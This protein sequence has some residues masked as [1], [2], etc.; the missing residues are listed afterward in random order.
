MAGGEG[1]EVRGP[2]EGRVAEVLSD[3]ALAFLASL[4]REFNPER[5]ALL[6]RR[7]ESQAR[8]V[9][10]ESL[11]FLP[12]TRELRD[13]EWKVAPPPKDLRDRRV[14]IT[15]PTDR[16]M[17]INAL[18]SGAR[19]FMADFEDSNSPT[20]AN[21]SEGHVNLIDAIEGT[22]SYRSPDGRDYRLGEE[23][24]TLL[25]RPRGWHLWDRHLLVEGEPIAGALMDFGLFFF[26]NARR[27]LDKGSGPYLYLPKLQSHLE[28]RLWNDVFNFSQDALGIDRGTIK[29]TVLIETVPAA[30]E[31]DEILYEL[32]DHS[33]GLNAGR[34]DY[35]FSMIKCFRTR[36]EFV[37]PDRNS[38]TMTVPFMRAYTQLLVN[39]CHRRG[40][41]AMGGM[42][43]FI[44][45][46][47]QPEI[48]EGAFAKVADDKRREATDGFDGTWIAHPD[49]VEVAQQEF[50]NVLADRPNQVDRVRDEVSV[51]AAE[52]LDVAATE[53]AITEEGLRNDC[54]VGIQYISSWLRGNGAAGIYNLMEDA[55]TAEI[56][57]SQVW[58]WVHTGQ[59]LEEGPAITPELVRELE[60]SELERIRGEIGDDDWFYREGRPD[61]SRSLFEQVALSDDFIEFLTIP[62]YERLE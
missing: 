9:A 43:A 46:R 40:A 18:N 6:D 47:R 51:G 55:A 1:I 42:A 60:E 59:R 31:M 8:L 15:G 12:A 26:H 27:L 58:Q 11:D 23:L 22:I 13:S 16:K 57:R 38:V 7:R 61:E 2:V 10:G 19:C 17:V 52:L 14:E 3:E 30:F 4:H 25:V 32:K 41:H 39:T 48:N 20:W 37:L 34:W 50:D 28:A 24:A 62:A 5:K 29:A 45:S 49:L 53:G 56:A 35:M 44:P 36:P 33:A 54:N 21:L